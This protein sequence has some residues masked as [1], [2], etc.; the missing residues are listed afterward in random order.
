MD[1]VDTH[2]H[3][4]SSDYPVPV[5]EVLLA[6]RQ[7]HVTKMI[8]VG[9]SLEDSQAA[10]AF[11]LK[12]DNA[13]AS[14]GV[15]PHE[16]KLYPDRQALLSALA[17]LAAQP[18]VVAIGECG[19]DYHYNHSPAEAQAEVLRVHLRVAQQYNLPVI[20]HVREAFSDF[21]PIFDEFA[22][23]TGV[24]HSFSA[25]RSDLAPALERGLY[26]GLNGIMTFTND[27][28]QLQAAKEVPLD[29][30]LLET[31]APFLTPTPYRG[32]ICEPKHV[33]VT[34]KFLADL[35]EEKLEELAKATTYNAQK[36]FGI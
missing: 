2:C 9:T 11:A 15:H 1:F 33:S 6:A 32:T 12:Q 8:C 25:H 31:D 19:L 27:P 28:E 21:W 10:E 30:L 24:M 35:R 7:A 34:A 20:F 5:D 26:I 14:I 29:K 36:L 16:A 23:I 3:I 22:G 18:K 13:W 4:H 17:T